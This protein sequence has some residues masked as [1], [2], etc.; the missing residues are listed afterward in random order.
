MK[1]ILLILCCVTEPILRTLTDGLPE[2][3]PGIMWPS[4]MIDHKLRLL[5]ALCIKNSLYVRS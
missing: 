3:A 2:V 5:L 1:V 4:V